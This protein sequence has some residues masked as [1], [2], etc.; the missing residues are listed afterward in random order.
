[1]KI[2]AGIYLVLLGGA[3]I[4]AVCFPPTTN[5]YN[6]TQVVEQSVD[7]ARLREIARQEAKCDVTV[8]VPEITARVER[9][10]VAVE[11]LGDVDERIVNLEET[12]DWLYEYERDTREIAGRAS[13]RVAEVESAVARIGPLDGPVAA[14]S[15][16]VGAVE[17]EVADTS[18]V[19]GLAGR[20]GQLEESAVKRGALTPLWVIVAVMA[21]AWVAACGVVLVRS[22]R[23]G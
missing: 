19:D 4:V 22:R 23:R 5:V 2:W 12:A 7:E 11:G 8:T 15:D 1:M 20:V 3:A 18:A 9:V 16:R 21:A 10:E 6:P 17:R 14:L 13:D